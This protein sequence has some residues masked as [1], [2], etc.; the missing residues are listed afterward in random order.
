MKSSI[1]LSILA[2]AS[3]T[4]AVSVANQMSSE[5]VQK[6]IELA[7]HQYLTGSA[8]GGLYALEA[9]ARVLESD[10][11][12]AELGPNNLSF[13][14]LRIGLLHE[15]AGN[16]PTASEYFAKAQQHYQGD[17]VELAQLK[18][19]VAKLDEMVVNVTPR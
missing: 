11:S 1:K 7:H 2:L 6:E 10:D 8:E 16:T 17:E 19:Y 15:Q 5:F 18:S 9:L 13:T 14:Y 3:L 12:Q 4:T